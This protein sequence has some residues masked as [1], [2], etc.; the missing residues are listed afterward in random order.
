MSDSGKSS[1]FEVSSMLLI[2]MEMAAGRSLWRQQRRIREGAQPIYIFADITV[3]S[4]V[5][6]NKDICCPIC[7]DMFVF[8]IVFQNI[9]QKKDADL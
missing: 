3:H 8:F 9:V 4:Q 1:K 2:S 7:A 6:P 5:Y